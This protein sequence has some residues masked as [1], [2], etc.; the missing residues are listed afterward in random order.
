MHAPISSVQDCLTEFL[1]G[2]AKSN[3]CHQPW[4]KS[5]IQKHFGFLAN[6]PYGTRL[7]R[8]DDLVSLYRTLGDRCKAFQNAQLGLVTSEK[9]LIEALGLRADKKWEIQA[10]GLRL[11]IAKFRLGLPPQAVDRQQELIL[12]EDR[13]VTQPPFKKSQITF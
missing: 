2:S 9:E 6:P 12:P 13:A 10:G 7:G 5:R 8:N 1:L 4:L 3:R 11:N